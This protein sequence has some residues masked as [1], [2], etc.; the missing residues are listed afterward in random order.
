MKSQQLE[1]KTS[2]QNCSFLISKDG[3]QVGCNAGRLEKFIEQDKAVFNENGYY[4]INRFCNMRRKEKLTVEDAY[5]KIKSKFGIAIFDEGK[6]FENIIESCKHIQYDKN[7]FKIS[8]YS[9]NKKVFGKLFAKIND[10]KK[11]GI[12]AKLFFDLEERDIS[13]SEKDVFQYLYGC[14]HLIKISDNAQIDPLFLSKIDNSLNND[15]EIFFTYELNNVYC[16][17]FWIVNQQYINHYNYNEMT[18]AIIEESTNNS[19]HK[20]YA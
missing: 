11:S 15:L 6:N 4:E 7:K 3:K 17:P 13:A 14:S 9:K 5:D 8:I 20:K 12:D 19:M 16:I 18:K 2:C 10:L 1:I